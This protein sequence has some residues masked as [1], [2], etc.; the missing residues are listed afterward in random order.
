[1]LPNLTR[2]GLTT[3]VPNCEDDVLVLLRL[4]A[5]DFVARFHLKNPNEA[6]SG[7]RSSFSTLEPTVGNVLTCTPSF[8][9]Y[10]GVLKSKI[11]SKV[12][13]KSQA[14]TGSLFCLLNPA[15][16]RLVMSKQRCS[17]TSEIAP[18]KEETRSRPTMMMHTSRF[19]TRCLANQES[20]SRR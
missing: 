10:L 7:N 8:S 2:S 3:K 19:P 6:N 15:K 5:Y 11:M 4:A 18:I 16:G 9:L 13:N 14:S 17:L 20:P 12:F 1:M